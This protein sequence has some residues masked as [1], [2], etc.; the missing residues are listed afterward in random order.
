MVIREV[1]GTHWAAGDVTLDERAAQSLGAAIPSAAIPSGAPVS[2]ATVNTRGV[3]NP[4]FRGKPTLS[5]AIGELRQRRAHQERQG[6]AFAG[7]LC[8]NYATS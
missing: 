4:D 3:R 1:P 2:G 6:K 8:P 5:T 7:V